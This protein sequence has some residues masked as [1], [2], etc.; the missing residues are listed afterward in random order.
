M[1]ILLLAVCMLFFAA[2]SGDAPEVKSPASSAEH[3]D[4][5]DE[6]K[7]IF[8]QYCASCHMLD[9][10]FTGPMLRGVLERWNNDRVKLKAFIRNSTDMIASGEP[11][12]LQA[13]QRGR[14]GTMPAFPDLSDNELEALINYVQN[15]H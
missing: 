13:K 4:S 14:G 5:G 11:L 15:G 3:R 7:L 1:R 10:D 6:G 12:A 9:K 8:Q 2:C